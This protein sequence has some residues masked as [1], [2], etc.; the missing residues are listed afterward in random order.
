MAD[1]AAK[2][3][4][5]DHRLALYLQ[6]KDAYYNGSQAIMSDSEFD[7]LEQELQREV[8]D[9]PAL[10]LVGA[11]IR[12][13]AKVPHLTPMLSM[14]KALDRPVLQSWLASRLRDFPGATVVATPKLDGMS[15]ELRYVAGLLTQAVSRGDGHAGVDITAKVRHCKGVPAFHPAGWTCRVRGELVLTYQ[16]FDDLNATLPEPL[17]NPRNGVVGLLNEAALLP[18]KLRFVTFRA[19]EY[20]HPTAPTYLADLALLKEHGF[21]SLALE[22]YLLTSLADLDS[23]LNLFEAARPHANTTWDGVI[24]RLNDAPHA[25]AAGRTEKFWKRAT[26]WKFPP[27]VVRVT[28]RSLEWSLGTRSLSPVAVFDPVTL[29]GAVI[30]RA[31]GKSLKNLVALGAY[32]GATLELRR[33]GGVIPWLQPGPAPDYAAAR[34]WLAAHV[35]TTCPGCRGPL[36][37]T[38][39]YTALLCKNPNC[40]GRLARQLEVLAKALGVKMLGPANCDALCRNGKVTRLAD[41]FEFYLEDFT[42]VLSEGVASA[43][44]AEVTAAKKRPHAPWKLLGSVGIARLGLD[45]ARKLILARGSLAAALD[46]TPEDVKKVLGIVNDELATALAAELE[47]KRDEISNLLA[48]GIET[49]TPDNQATQHRLPPGKTNIVV[50]GDLNSLSREDFKSFLE[51]HGIKLSGAVSRNTACLV[52]NNPATQTTKARDAAKYG[53]PVLTEAQLWPFLQLEP[54]SPKQPQEG[55]PK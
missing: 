27:D 8:P 30:R 11:K 34:E 21:H 26:A 12:D 15:C 20:D 13:T 10:K 38:K 51:D 4:D 22:A 31:G 18:D 43:V 1:Y 32:P 39:D 52:T 45:S 53:I 29:D 54:P 3:T 2:F 47:D 46:S 7:D 50:T 23:L 49:A 35:P 24:F 40:G 44:W 25:L 5:L 48:A 6:A 33:S 9:H 14:E 16:D 55:D 17:A 19:F 37:F 41:I 42:Q 28:V 36:E